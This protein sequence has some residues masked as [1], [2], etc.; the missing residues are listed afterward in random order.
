MRFCPNDGSL[1]MPVRKGSAAVL[2]CPK[3][4]Y[5][6]PINDAARSAYR[7]KSVVYRRI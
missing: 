4:G 5:E 3:C 1:L 6:E 2:R 7:S